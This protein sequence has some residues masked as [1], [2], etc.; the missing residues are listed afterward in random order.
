MTIT[1][2]DHRKVKFQG[3]AFAASQLAGNVR[4]GV[5]QELVE[6]YAAGMVDGI[7]SFLTA[8]VSDKA[9]YDVLQAAA[10]KAVTP[11]VNQAAGSP[12]GTR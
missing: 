1:A 3:E 4:G 8:Y 7:R 2:E 12:E 9:A 6:S 11:S 10:D 5:A